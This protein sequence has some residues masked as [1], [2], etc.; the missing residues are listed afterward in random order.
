MIS[1][2]K[3]KRR[4]GCGFHGLV[5][6]SSISDCTSCSNGQDRSARAADQYCWFWQVV[7]LSASP[8][9]S[10]QGKVVSTVRKNLL[11]LPDSGHRALCTTAH[12]RQNIQL[13]ETQSELTWYNWSQEEKTWKSLNGE[14]VSSFSSST[15]LLQ[16]FIYVL[17]F[18]APRPP[19]KVVGEQK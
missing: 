8:F 13:I 11:M 3:H 5:F 10:L 2:C 12:Y 17:R 6:A 4:C 15:K 7:R 16:F 9:S 19:R 14:P 1:R 18:S